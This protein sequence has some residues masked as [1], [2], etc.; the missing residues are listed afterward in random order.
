MN[1]EELVPERLRERHRAG[2]ARYRET[3]HGPY[4]DSRELLDLPALRKA[5][6]ELRIEPGDTGGTHVS[7][8]L[9]LGKG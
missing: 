9:P 6:G 3:G 8:R 1:L 7:A 4:I 2:L 5:G